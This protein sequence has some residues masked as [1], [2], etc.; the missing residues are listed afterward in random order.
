MRE[1]VEQLDEMA[2]NLDSQQAHCQSAWTNLRAHSRSFVPRNEA[3]RQ[4]KRRSPRPYSPSDKTPGH[5]SAP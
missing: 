2:D 5:R 3:F 4:S 1:I